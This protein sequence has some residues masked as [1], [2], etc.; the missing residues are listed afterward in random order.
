MNKEDIL[1]LKKL[2]EEE[3]FKP[4]IDKSFPIEDIVKAYEYVETGMKTGNVILT[5]TN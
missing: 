1:F 4:V 3:H 2:V 5:V